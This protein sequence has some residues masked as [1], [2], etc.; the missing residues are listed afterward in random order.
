MSEPTWY[1]RSKGQKRGP[2]TREKLLAMYRQGQIGTFHEVSEDGLTW[3]K[4]ATLVV[5]A[6]PEPAVLTLAEEPSRA[7][8]DSQT[9]IS[10]ETSGPWPNTVDPDGDRLA[11]D[12]R[13]RKGAQTRRVALL[14]IPLLL[15][16]IL[17]T[18]L[19]YLIK[20]G[21]FDLWPFAGGTKAILALDN[22]DDVGS[23]VGFVIVG[24]EY[25]LPD[26]SERVSSLGTGS[27]AAVTADGFLLTNRHVVEFYDRLHR[28]ERIERVDRVER[29]AGLEQ[30]KEA[31]IREL[32]SSLPPERREEF[33]K[34]FRGD[35]MAF[36]TLVPR[37][38]VITKGEG[39]RIE[40]KVA[41]IVKMCEE[42]EFD[43]AILKIERTPGPY[44]RISGD[45][46]PQERSKKVEALGFPGTTQKL[47]TDE[48]KLLKQ[49][50]QKNASRIEKMFNES[51]FSY[52]QTPG[53]VTKPHDETK[54]G[55]RWIQHNAPITHGNSGGPLV[56][57]RG[58]ILGLNTL[59]LQDGSTFRA[60]AVSQ[61]RPLIEE[62]VKDAEFVDD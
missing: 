8:Y 31:I 22:A 56:D 26:G 54:G 28:I 48:E 13:A 18:G 7:P 3:S 10:S 53:A 55:R 60:L 40:T 46:K 16:S 4:A 2:F 44:F 41:R 12:R 21:G 37:L 34:Q 1:V 24:F 51:D 19:T 36:K 6:T 14:A 25:T 43:F 33:A 35:L 49:M 61:L 52:V 50:R 20:R 47:M 42:N 27:C 45:E 39:G 59:G 57:S 5:E 62:F 29:A 38:W 15:G 17:L 9:P 23:A 32:A 30:I 11:G 58:V